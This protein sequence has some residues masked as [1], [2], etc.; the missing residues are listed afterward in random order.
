METEAVEEILRGIE[1]GR[2]EYVGGDVVMYEIE[3]N[4]DQEKRSRLR[5]MIPE[6]G[7]YVDLRICE[8]ITYTYLLLGMML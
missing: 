6:Q 2:F 8:K 1:E 7:F 4:S 5:S 3:R